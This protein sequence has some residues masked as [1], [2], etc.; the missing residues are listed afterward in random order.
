MFGADE[1]RRGLGGDIIILCIAPCIG[2][3]LVGSSMQSVQSVRCLGWGQHVLM[4]QLNMDDGFRGWADRCK[5]N[6][7]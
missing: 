5:V 7:R 2:V 4:K 1:A 6:D 3:G